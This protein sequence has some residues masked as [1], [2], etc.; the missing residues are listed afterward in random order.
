MEKTKCNSVVLSAKFGLTRTCDF[1]RTF[2]PPGNGAVLDMVCR[3]VTRPLDGDGVL[4]PVCFW[5]VSCAMI[6]NR[7]NGEVSIIV[8]NLADGS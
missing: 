8:G 5:I 4:A 3:T 7:A 1:C 2:S 6:Y